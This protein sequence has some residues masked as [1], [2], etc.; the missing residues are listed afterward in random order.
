[1][2][3]AVPPA[4]TGPDVA[5]RVAG[6][7]LALTGAPDT[8]AVTCAVDW[9]G[10]LDLALSGERDVQA[11]CGL[12]HVHGRAAGRPPRSPWTTPPPSPASSPP[13]A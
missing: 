13:R 8:A 12:M 4:R 9:S 3:L 11:A 7:L 2:T 10:P 5:R 1:M 6:R